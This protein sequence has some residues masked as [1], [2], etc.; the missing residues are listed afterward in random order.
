MGSE[1]REPSGPTTGGTFPYSVDMG[2][3][4]QLA[5]SGGI[6]LNLFEG[7]DWSG[8]YEGVLNKGMQGTTTSPTGTPGFG[9]YGTAIGSQSALT[10]MGMGDIANDPRLQKY[11]GD[12]PQFSQ[13]YRQ[14]FGDIQKGGRQSLSQM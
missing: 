8:L 6:D 4:Q 3:I 7:A 10:Q 13:G 2:D 9:D 12:L 5:Q 11:L 1:T 14:Q